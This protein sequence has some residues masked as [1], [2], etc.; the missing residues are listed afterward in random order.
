MAPALLASAERGVPE[1]VPRQLRPPPVSPLRERQ[2][3]GL[4]E[5]ALLS[6]ESRLVGAGKPWLAWWSL[7][8]ELNRRV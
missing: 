2:V 4:R 8:I 5:V 3:S 7:R 1:D 6:V